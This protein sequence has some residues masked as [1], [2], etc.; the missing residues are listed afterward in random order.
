MKLIWE[1]MEEQEYTAG[2]GCFGSREGLFDSDTGYIVSFLVLRAL[3]RSSLVDRNTSL[4][5]LAHIIRSEYSLILF[6]ESPLMI[7][8]VA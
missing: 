7:R 4:S 6:A 1:S 3:V 8:V 5:S 2:P